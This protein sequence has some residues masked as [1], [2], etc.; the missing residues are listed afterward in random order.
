MCIDYRDLNRANPKDD[1]LLPHIDV[2]IDSTARY[3]MMSFMDGFLAYNQI[4][5]SIEYR[6][7]TAFT[8]PWSTFCYKVM[9]FSLK[10]VRA[11]YQWAMTALFHDMIN[12]EMEVYVDDMI[13]KSHHK[14]DHLTHLRKLSARLRKYKLKLN[15]NKFIFGASYGK[16]LGFITSERGIEVD[17]SEAKVIIGMPIPWTEKDVHSFL[18][19][20][21]YISRFITQLTP[22]CEPLFK[23]LRKNVLAQWNDNCQAAFEKIKNYLL[24]QPVLISLEPNCPLILYLT[25]H[26]CSMG[27]VLGQYDKTRKKEKSIYYLSK[28]FIDY[29]TQ[30]TPLKKTYLFMVYI[31]KRLLH[32]FLLYKK[33]LISWINPI[34][35]LFETPATIRRTA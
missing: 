12:K 30:Y 16:L 32:Y 7:K 9:P 20:V 10:N 3:E 34:K 29:K 17:P 33:F 18:G 1:L 27:C 22:I 21:Q 28:C 24:S 25:V 15:P 26:D 2:L 31:T 35:Y 14:E 19:H 5:M 6:K 13:V 4:R 8:T 11:T 23:L